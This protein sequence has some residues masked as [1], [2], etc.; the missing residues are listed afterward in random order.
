MRDGIVTVGFS[1]VLPGILG[2]TGFSG[3]VVLGP[4]LTGG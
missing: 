2:F 4:V 3:V 1:S